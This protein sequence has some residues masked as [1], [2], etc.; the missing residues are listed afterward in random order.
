LFNPFDPIT[1]L[2]NLAVRTWAN[3]QLNKIRHPKTAYEN[4]MAL[5]M[6]TLTITNEPVQELQGCHRLMEAFILDTWRMTDLKPVTSL[7][8]QTIRGIQVST[9][10]MYYRLQKEFPEVREDV[11]VF[12]TAAMSEILGRIGH[13]IYVPNSMG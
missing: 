3:H 13:P 2:T 11:Q 5:N 6:D 10:E 8:G 4:A 1:G 7:P 9:V 12:Q